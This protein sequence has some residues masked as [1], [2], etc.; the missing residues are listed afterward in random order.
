MKLRD[1]LT[2]Y[3]A[4]LMTAV[5]AFCA[6]PMV[7]F[8]KD[9][10]ERTVTPTTEAADLTDAWTV[11]SE[12]SQEITVPSLAELYGNASATVTPLFELTERR[13][14]H[15]KHIRMSDGSTVAAVYPKPVHRV[16]EDGALEDIDNTLT[17][18][19]S[20][21]TSADAR[22][23]LA[24]KITGNERLY[25]LHDGSYKLTMSLVGAIKGTAGT[26]EN[27]EEAEGET[28]LAKMLTL[29]KLTSRVTYADILDGV[30]VEYV[31]DALD[32]KENIIVKER[33]EHYVYTFVLA[34]NGLAATLTAS[35]AI[36]ITDSQTGKAVYTM[37]AP[38][39]LDASGVLAPDGTAVY[40]LTDQGN[41]K[42]T[43]TVTA[44]PTWMQD[45]ARV[46][47][48]T[49]DPTV[50]V[51]R[52]GI[53][54]VYVSDDAP[55]VAVENSNL[56]LRHNTTVYI[57]LPSTYL[58]NI[59]R[60][61]YVSEARLYVSG[62]KYGSTVA[63]VRA[64]EVTTPFTVS[65]NSDGTYTFA[66]GTTASAVLDAIPFNA[67][68]LSSY[69][70]NITPVV[71][72]HYDNAGG[73]D[74]ALRA[75]GLSE[76]DS[77]YA[78][79]FPTEG[80]YDGF[81]VWPYL[82]VRYVEASGIEDY[83]PSETHTVG[84]AGSGSIQLAAGTLAFLL[85]TLSTTDS[86][87]PASPTLV[88]NSAM[89]GAPLTY[90]NCDSGYTTAA[91]A[92]GFQL[93]LQQT[94]VEIVCSDEGY[95]G[96]YLIYKDGD[97]TEHYFSGSSGTYRDQA[98][99]G[100][101]INYDH[102]LSAYIMTYR[103]GTK[104]YFARTSTTPSGVSSAWYLYKIEDANGN[105]LLID[106]NSAKHPT[107]LK[108][109][110]AGAE[111]ANA[112]EMLTFVYSGG[113]LRAI[114]NDITGDAVLLG[115]A[116]STA[117]SISSGASEY[118]RTVVYA[119]SDTVRGSAWAS[120]YTESS[121]S[122]VTVLRTTQLSYTEDGSLS[123]VLDTESK[124]GIQYAWEDH[125]LTAV[126]EYSM[127]TGNMLM[128]QSIAITTYTGFAEV[129][130]SGKDDD[131]GDEDDILTRY[132]MDHLGRAITV[133]SIS[134]DGKTLYGATS[135]EY[136]SQENARNSL[137]RIVEGGSTVSLVIDGGFEMDFANYAYWARNSA[138]TVQQISDASYKEQGSRK[139]VAFL[140]TT[141]TPATLTQALLLPSGDYA[142]AFDTH[143]Q[144]CANIVGTVSMI[145]ASTGAVLHTETVALNAASTVAKEGRFAT[146][147]T[148]PE[149]TESTTVLLRISFTNSA[150]TVP[151]I[152]VDNVTLTPG[153]RASEFS[154]VQNGGFEPT[155]L[156]SSTLTAY[157]NSE[158]WVEDRSNYP[159]LSASYALQG[160][161]GLAVS[162]W[163]DGV[164]DEVYQ[165]VFTA[166]AGERAA[167]DNSRSWNFEEDTA[168][169]LSGF[170]KLHAENPVLTAPFGIRV[171]IS[172]YQGAGIAPVVRSYNLSFNPES[173]GWQ[174]ASMVIPL[175]QPG[176]REGSTY[177]CVSRIDISCQLYDMPSAYAYFD[178]VSFVPLTTQNSTS[179][180]YN[181]K[182]LC[183]ATVSEGGNTYY[184][185][186]DHEQLTR[187]A[188][189]FGEYTDYVYDTANPYR[190]L[191]ETYGTFTRNNAGSGYET[192]YPYIYSNPDAQITKTQKTVT[193]YTYN[194]Y[195]Q[196]T[197]SVTTQYF[198][199]TAYQ[200][201]S[202]GA[203]YLA[204][205]TSPFVGQ[206][207]TETDSYGN[208]V[209]YL[210]DSEDGKLIA[211]VD[212]K[213]YATVYQ[214]DAIDRLIGVRPGT[215]SASTNTA[216]ADTSNTAE[217]VQYTYN[218]RG[219][220]ETVTT[221]STVYRFT[222]D[223]FGNAASTQVGEQ[224]VAS[225][226]YN[227]QNGKLKTV[228]YANGF[229]EEYVYGALDRITEIWY[230]QDGVSTQAFEYLYSDDGN[231]L[232]FDNLLA[233]EVTVYRYDSAGRLISAA[234]AED[235]TYELYSEYSYDAYSALQSLS[236]TVALG[237]NG[238][239]TA[240]YTYEYN[241]DRTL[242]YIDTAASMGVLYS[243]DTLGRL[244]WKN[245]VAHDNGFRIQSNYIYKTEDNATGL[246]V[247]QYKTNICYG[248]ETVLNYTY[249][250]NGNITEILDQNGKRI[251]YT[252]DDRGQLL[253]ERNEVLGKE[254]RYTYNAAGN[255][256]SVTTTTLSTNTSTTVSLTYGSGAWGDALA[257]YNGETI[258][259]DSL[260]NPLVYY[261]YRTF[262]WDGRQF[263]GAWAG[264]GYFY[265]YTYDDTGRRI[266]KTGEGM[267]TDYV[268]DGDRMI[269]EV[270]NWYTIVYIYD[271][272]NV[273]I[274]ML[275]RASDDTLWTKYWFEKNLQGDIIAIWTHGGV[276][277]VSYTYDAWG[278][279]TSKTHYNDGVGGYYNNRFLYRGYYWDGDLGL[280]WT[281]TRLYD[282]VT[283]RFIN[284]DS[285]LYFNHIHGC[286][287]YAYCNN[288]PVNYYDPTGES[289]KVLVG[290]NLS[291]FGV[292][293]NVDRPV[294]LQSSSHFV[295]L[296]GTYN[297][298]RN[299]S[300]GD[301]NLESHHAIEKRF[302]VV[303]GFE[304]YR[305]SPGSA[306]SIILDK[307][308]HRAITNAFREK[309]KYGGNYQSLTFEQVQK[310]AMDIYREFGRSDLMP[311]VLEYIH[312]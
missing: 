126:T 224:T 307:A 184:T 106:V 81:G 187:V 257:S 49:V 188:N 312:S 296:T 156:N 214:Y 275:Y 238:S 72:T 250:E 53:L 310:M 203:T 213:G 107:A 177:A 110:P 145:N 279:Y 66:G 71:R 9:A 48:I 242:K 176:D 175:Y 123:S 210:Y 69:S 1:R 164:G 162:M 88:Y 278:N 136:S 247:S 31:I 140:P 253:T 113:I 159:S 204:T 17:E 258:T 124:L 68:G 199:G 167:Y 128:G 228:T 309:F 195:G 54:D 154:L 70:F 237:A 290:N 171:D 35:G 271:D 201:V 115:Y 73:M 291:S 300:R 75:T 179:Y 268:Y 166:T 252:Y 29:S 50:G 173:E 120:A 92:Y 227:D 63:T 297:E 43:L 147:F 272:G 20:D 311:T 95:D 207:L 212:A 223:A 192:C 239:Y 277:C 273:P 76:T 270:S 22:I 274:G 32:V 84:A 74:I 91:T 23:K 288:N 82:E 77:S 101:V 24:K 89:A 205:A 225:Y 97:G 117:G 3:V 40:A 281:Q 133:Y 19:G 219:M 37:P 282:P 221:G 61:A 18:D 263:L 209:R 217:R 243:Y 57:H 169:L 216:T 11:G 105:A 143:S 229:A 178:N 240:D 55:T 267:T 218:G 33:A 85:P 30:D 112:I 98:A 233:D 153:T 86:I 287:M 264:P 78:T 27:G 183:V 146:T 132:A 7:A 141:A 12:E 6:V 193:A 44:D 235:D 93:S 104:Q 15:T 298:L 294:V 174:Y 289:P 25:T 67:Y 100:R 131:L 114:C 222:F 38:V 236:Y 10:E 135:G 194:T 103:D 41:G 108:L 47:P 137:A 245:F 45:A 4:M 111:E 8:A 230:I 251:T 46:Y 64:Y 261:N 142:V 130:S 79:V 303:A 283:G 168:F 181:T 152:H 190:L 299:Y 65:E 241:T 109:L 304:K 87:M 295:G 39:V 62:N 122:N 276:K 155:A 121:T 160:D 191:T 202:G 262:E 150:S 116:S 119:H 186:D 149:A 208:T 94:L 215:Y 306:P 259:Y 158:F 170:A 256:T 58:P 163:S 90:G 206:L 232:R 301:P 302:F 59:G 196:S 161:Q 234:T 248:D 269:A 56:Y 148:V 138:D 144:Q 265:G 172:Y 280:Y 125:R 129:R 80:L 260:G 21:F 231:L 36:T 134:P 200:T 292:L 308:T 285:A 185:Y 83:Y 286:N 99:L 34:L 102:D 182:G 151:T 60:A 293:A 26:V 197:G 42:Y 52:N 226:A 139:S 198:N 249:D 13:D 246:L 118:L 284:P 211:T 5:M 127:S 28:A 157:D 165:T 96:Y 244:S 305:A 189:D 51:A 14:V 16:G 255:R 180:Y 266:Q 220:L 2:R 254:L